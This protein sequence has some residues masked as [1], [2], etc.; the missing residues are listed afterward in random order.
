[1]AARGTRASAVRRLALPLALAAAVVPVGVAVAGAGSRQIVSVT[2]TSKRTSAPT[3]LSIS[4]DY[5]NPSDP[6]G[7]PPAVRRVV[8][9]LAPGSTIDP[10]ALPRCGASDAELMA[11][12]SAACPNSVVGGGTLDLDTGIPGPARIIS[13]DVTL[14][15]ADGELI[16]LTRE[17]QSGARLVNRARLSG[18]RTMT[19]DVPML[20]GA[21]PDGT[22]LKTVRLSI[23]KIVNGPR[24][25]LRT[26]PRCPSTRRFTGHATFTYADG[27]S[28]TI[29]SS[30]ACVRP[31]AT[32]PRFTG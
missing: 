24:A 18:A 7:K 14:I 29:A 12:G 30:S 6:S 15:N 20:P 21:P 1:M 2:A 32:G 5:R 10:L 9:R 23:R 8:T 25:Y 4:I 28:Q 3:G 16:F 19:S 27:V 13:N 31:A 26:P 17:K 11:Q 22:A